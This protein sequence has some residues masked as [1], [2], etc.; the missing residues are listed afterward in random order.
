MKVVIQR[1]N[2]KWLKVLVFVLMEKHSGLLDVHNSSVKIQ[3]DTMPIVKDHA[4]VQTQDAIMKENAVK[5]VTKTTKVQIVK[6]ANVKIMELV[7]KINVCATTN[8]KE[9]YVKC[10]IVS[11]VGLQYKIQLSLAK[12]TNAIVGTILEA[13]IAKNVCV[14]MAE[15]VNGKVVSA[16]KIGKENFVKNENVKMMGLC[17]RLASACV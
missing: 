6:S 7:R 16:R 5:I 4:N 15:L 12:L 14:K 9:I 17:L 8:L 2:V 11:M 10:Q 1:W 13:P 3:L